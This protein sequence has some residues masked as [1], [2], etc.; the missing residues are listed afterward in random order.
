[1]FEKLLEPDIKIDPL[2][3]AS[4]AEATV[5]IHNYGE[6]TDHDL[7]AVLQETFNLS[8]EVAEHIAWVARTTGTARVVTLPRH[9]ALRLVH[10]A[11]VTAQLYGFTLTPGLE[12]PFRR[13][14]EERKPLKESQAT[15]VPLA[16]SS[17][18]LL[19]VFFVA[20]GLTVADRAGGLLTGF[21]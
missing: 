18:M 2:V 5:L 11:R 3:K 9:E 7:I 12:F 15:V 17:L 6:P 10:Q 16:I 20:I 8:Y 4:I 19:A 13:K 1:M 21:P 14:D